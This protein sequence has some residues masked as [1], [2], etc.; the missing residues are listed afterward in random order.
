MSDIYIVDHYDGHGLNDAISVTADEPDR[1][2]ASHHYEAVLGGTLVA[3]IQFQQG[4]RNEPSSTPGATEAVVLAI[5]IDRLR[6]FQSGPYPCRE[7]AIMLTKLEE[8]LHWTRAR[9]DA[10]ARRGVL[11]KSVK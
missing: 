9:A 8:C 6:G 5:L 10:R 11:G 3:T 4:P 2:G 1:H 7:N